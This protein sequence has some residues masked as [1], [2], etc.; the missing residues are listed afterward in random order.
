MNKKNPTLFQSIIP[1]VILMG[2]IALNVIL[3]PDDTIGGANQLSLLMASGVAIGIALYNGIEW[4][5]IVDKMVY[6]VSSATSSILILLVIGLLSGTWM[7]SGVVP[8]MIYYGLKIIN[9]YFFLPATIIITAIISVVVGSSWSTVATVGIALLGIGRALGFDDGLIA[10][11][12]ISGAYFGDKISPLSDTTN[13]AAAIAKVPIFKHI[14]YMMQTTVP[15]FIITLLIFIGISIFSSPEGVTQESEIEQVIGSFYNVSPFL[16]LVPLVVV[17]MIAKRFPTLVVLTLGGLIGGVVAIFSQPHIIT[18]LATEGSTGAL[19][20][21]EVLCRAMFGAT[22]VATGSEAVDSLL[23]TGGMAGM[24]STIWLIIM[25]MVFG[26]VL[27]AGLFLEKIVSTVEKRVSTPGMAVTTTAGASVMFNLTSGDQ[28]MAIVVPGKMFSALFTRLKL[29]PELLSRTL[30]D[31]GTVTSVLIPWNTCGATQAAILG[32]ATSVYAPFAF[33]C[34]L[35]P[36]M[37]MLFAWLKIKIKPLK[38]DG[39]EDK[40]VN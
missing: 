9:P 38:E 7:L 27:E 16:L 32:V 17:F 39:G 22:S 18:S 24:L 12:I 33:F 19:G 4:K 2:L 14:K 1:I 10:G 35:S 3:M 26:G 29:R 13:L 34:Y 40:T 37:T 21:Y 15:T 8:T 31:A 5:D 6:T 20:I 11:A 30:E 25:A 36:F 28:Y 23:S